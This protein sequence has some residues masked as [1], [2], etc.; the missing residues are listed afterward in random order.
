MEDDNNLEDD[1]LQQEDEQEF[2]MDNDNILLDED[3]QEV[4][5]N[6]G[7]NYFKD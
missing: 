2:D 4:T 5:D 3:D 6:F 7:E 1:F